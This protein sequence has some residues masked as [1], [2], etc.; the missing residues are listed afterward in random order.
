MRLCA[1]VWLDGIS[2]QRALSRPTS[3]EKSPVFPADNWG[4]DL[5]ANRSPLPKEQL[6]RQFLPLAPVP[7]LP[8]D[9]E[10]KSLCCS[11]D[12]KSFAFAAVGLFFHGTA[13][14]AASI[15]PIVP[16]FGLS[17]V[18]TRTRIAALID[19][20][21]VRLAQKETV[22]GTE[23]WTVEG[24][25]QPGLSAV[26]FRFGGENLE[27]VELQYGEPTW[28][29]NQYGEFMEEIKQELDHKYG[30]AEILAH[31]RGPEKDVS[32]TVV[33]YRWEQPGEALDLVYYSAEREPLAFRL[34]SM[35]YKLAHR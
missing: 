2:S 32:Q 30:R 12:M 22:D 14:V 20:A 7:T 25:D 35:H 10:R 8:T 33:G 6:L 16:P 27:E 34:L 31:S 11:K 3:A 29:I 26:L 28:T 23:T 13:L 19:E 4:I 18:E 15:A 17:G 1:Q 9:V 5:E 21:H 24:F